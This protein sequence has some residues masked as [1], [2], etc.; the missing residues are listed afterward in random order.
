MGL[1]YLGHEHHLQIGEVRLAAKEAEIM[2]KVVYWLGIGAVM[3]A[4]AWAVWLSWHASSVTHPLVVTDRVRVLVGVAALA[5]LPW[6]GRR[7]GWFGPVGSTITA[8]LVRVA[9]CASVCGLGIALVRMDS[10][11]GGVDVGV[12][13]A[14]TLLLGDGGDPIC[15]APGMRL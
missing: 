13:V 12:D 2:R 6:M 11:V 9:G 5:V 8:R 10:D 4:A 1:Q 15:W 14:G 7:R 3:A